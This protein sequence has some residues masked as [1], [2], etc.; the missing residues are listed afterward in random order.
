MKPSRFN[1]ERPESLTEALELLNIASAKGL[2]ARIM[3]GGQSLIPMMNYRIVKPDLVIDISRLLELD[4]IQTGAS[5]GLVA[6]ALS[7]HSTMERSDLVAQH[8]PVVPEALQHVAHLAVRNMGTIGGSLAHA[9]PAAEW[10]LLVRL[11]DATLVVASVRGERRI[12]ASDFFISMLTTAIERD[13][14][15]TQ[16]EF[17]FLPDGSGS[18]FDE[19][20]RR[21]GDYALAGVGVCLTAHDGHVRQARVALMGVGDTPL[22]SPDAE[23]VLTGQAWS[24]DLMQRAVEQGCAALTPRQDLNAS[25]DYRRHLTAV[26]MAQT[27]KTAWSRATGAAQ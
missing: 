25:S 26:L 2:E 11:L 20:S 3:A 10:P 12:A 8:F 9:D 21:H 16:I 18:T 14:L 1:Y 22:R 19:F 7:R 15:L 24:E 13:E 5:G 6:G 27:L 4:R 23:A 17:P